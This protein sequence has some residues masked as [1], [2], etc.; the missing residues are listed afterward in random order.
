MTKDVIRELEEAYFSV[1]PDERNILDALAGL[2]SDAKIFVDVGASIGQYTYRSSQILS[3]GRIIAIEPDP[4]RFN[5]L[6]RNCRRWSAESGNE[7]AAINS[8]ITDR[9]EPV[10]FFLTGSTVSGRL[11]VPQVSA[12]V[13]WTP[14]TVTGSTLD[15]LLGDTTPDFVKIDVEGAEL[16]VLRG[17]ERLLE[18]GTT[19]FLVEIHGWGDPERHTGRVAT[20][21]WMLHYGYL[22]AYF[23]GNFL[24]LRP[25]LYW[26]GTFCRGLPT[27]GRDAIRRL[28][29]RRRR[30][31]TVA[32]RAQKN[33]QA[34][35]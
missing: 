23:H 8:V 35:P 31:G 18:K 24:F 16:R 21:R 26:L 15:R 30:V 6:E 14:V 27:F 22:P 32:G 20:F 29:G 33:K 12:G 19:R 25:S 13:S 2:L 4:A 28:L 17:A 7:I 9:D 34:L 5:Q 11:S 10:E 1:E 3:N